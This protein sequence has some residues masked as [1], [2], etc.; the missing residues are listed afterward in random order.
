[1]KKIY[2]AL[3]FVMIALLFSSCEKQDL[4]TLSNELTLKSIRRE[5]V[6]TDFVKSATFNQEGQILDVTLGLISTSEFDDIKRVYRYDA[7]NLLTCMTDNSNGLPGC[8]PAFE[9]EGGVITMMNGNPVEYNGNIIIQLHLTHGSQSIYTFSDNSYQQ[10]LKVEHF[11]DYTTNPILSKQV[12]FEY[13]GDNLIFFEI[14]RL[15]DETGEF[16]I[17]NET[18]YTYDDNPNPFRKGHS[19]IAMVSYYQSMLDLTW[20][21]FNLIYRSANN[22]TQRDSFYDHLDGFTSNVIDYSY[23]YNSIGYPITRTNQNGSNEFLLK[24]DYYE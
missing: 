21:E 11:R 17:I 19:Q 12:V 6:N 15:D 13:E 22:V 1:M 20:G 2:A 3:P 7:Q 9:Y 10:L 18:R 5:V 4:P 14:K 16:Q 24:Y 8:Y 23:E